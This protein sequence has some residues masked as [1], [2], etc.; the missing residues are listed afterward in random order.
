MKQ[1]KNII[2]KGFGGKQPGAGR[3]R[4]AKNKSTIFKA[5]TL[6]EVQEAI[7][8]MAGKLITGH[9]IAATGSHQIAI[10]VWSDN[11]LSYRRVTDDEKMN[12]LLT[13]GEYGKDYVVFTSM[14]P[15]WRAGDAL[16]NRAFGK[17]IESVELSGKDGK[18]LLI[19]LNE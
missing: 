9:A 6:E 18:P 12:A 14:D 15:D 16:M 13:E 8:K 10:P 3:P 5:Q 4:G 2:R 19:K 17:P 7:K 1:K 11:K